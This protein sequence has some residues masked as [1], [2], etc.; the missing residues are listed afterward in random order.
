MI[1][2]AYNESTW[3]IEL[4]KL[5]SA[6]ADRIRNYH[7]ER[8]RVSLAAET[9]VILRVNPPPNPNQEAWDN[10]LARASWIV[11]SYDI[12]GFHATR[13]TDDEAADIVANGM[14]PLSKDLYER[15]IAQAVAAKVLTAD[16]AAR[17]GTHNQIGD[18][19]RSGMIWFVFTRTQLSDE[20]GIE[21]LFRSWGGEALYNSHEDNVLTGPLLRGIGRPRIIVAAVPAAG[22]QCFMDVGQRLVNIWCAKHRI[23]TGHYPHFEGY[24]R[25]GISGRSILR[26][27]DFIDEEF[28]DLTR[29]T[30][31]NRPL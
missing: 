16:H 17:L 3:P 30:E 2:D 24:V 21:R 9:N 22:I 28:L 27:I 8:A 12:L 6:D 11:R 13:L 4:R 29:Y 23:H 15:R 7:I 14:R 10:V 25:V 31:W 18:D 1:I 5:L 19:N 20:S 26:V